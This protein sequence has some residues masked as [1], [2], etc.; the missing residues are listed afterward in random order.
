[1][2]EIYLKL[3]LSN[4]FHKEI[5][6]FDEHP[7]KNYIDCEHIV[8]KYYVKNIIS[9]TIYILQS[10]NGVNWHW[11]SETFLNNCVIRVVNVDADAQDVYKIN[12]KLRLERPHFFNYMRLLSKSMSYSVSNIN[13]F[14]WMDR[15]F[16]MWP[17]R[18]E[19]TS[20]TWK[21]CL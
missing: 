3:F 19:I 2:I 14:A 7:S 16:S 10:T 12:R 15:C 4:K 13:I 17:L 6:L 21:Y 18:I 8:G 9:W 20:I 1:M 5:Q 11:N